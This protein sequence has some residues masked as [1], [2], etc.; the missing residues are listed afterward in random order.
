MIEIS[1]Q[2]VSA[3]E[4]G[5]LARQLRSKLIQAGV[6]QADISISRTDSEA[7]DAGSL[8][9]LAEMVA[10]YLAVPHC[11]M[12]LWEISKSARAGFVIRGPRGAV[13]EF[14][15]NDVQ[16]ERLVAAISM[17]THRTDESGSHHE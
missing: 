15:P 13:F 12:I 11:A 1:F 2:D 8:L 7:M 10:S 17:I 9:H 6:P 5:A 14:K 4:A 3:A 16:Y